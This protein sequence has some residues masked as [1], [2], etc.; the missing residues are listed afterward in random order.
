MSEKC[1]GSPD[2]TFS[3]PVVQK[4]SEIRQQEWVFSEEDRII[5]KEKQ[6]TLK[7]KSKRALVDAIGYFLPK[8]WYPTHF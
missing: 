1:K 5:R 7:E 8:G 6:R 3:A 4:Y 2:E